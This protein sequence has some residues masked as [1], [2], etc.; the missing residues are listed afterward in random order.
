M[1]DE[2]DSRSFYVTRIEDGK[3]KVDGNHPLAGQALK[4]TV[5]IIEVVEDPNA[6]ARQ[7]VEKTNFA[8][9]MGN[10]V[11]LYLDDIQHT[12]SELLQKFISLCDAQR[13]IEGVWTRVRPLVL[14]VLLCMPAV[15][16]N[17]QG[18]RLA[19]FPLQTLGSYAQQEL[20]SEWASPDFHPLDML[21]FLALLLATWSSLVFSGQ[22]VAG[23]EWL[24]LLGF[25][26]M[27]LRSGR[28]LGL[29][30][31]VAAPILFSHGLL[32]MTRLGINWGRR[33]SLAPALH[34][35]P[36]LNWALLILML[37]AAG[38]KAS[39]SLAP[40]T[41]SQEHNKVFPVDAAAHMRE[42]DL[43]PELFNDYGWGGYLIWALY[44]ETLV[45]IDGRA[46][47]FGDALIQDYS[48]ILTARPG[49]QDLLDEYRV[50]TALVSAAS[51]LAAA[52]SESKEWQAAYTDHLAAVFVRQ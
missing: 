4:V 33:P 37:F 15:L 22:K 40:Q 48:Q 7:E 1:R 19:L 52:M 30:A 14:I 39:W 25:T 27:A 24:R 9:E 50:R 28:Y 44:P 49:W 23:A 26:V 5:K 11:M 6:T 46:D 43:P 13:R 21:P 20:I 17:P 38:A 31:V 29:C 47:P 16:I 42:A 45:F 36:M 34:G 2:G 32:V 51:A 41:I 35:A 12:S 8:F 3:L 18:I 10:N